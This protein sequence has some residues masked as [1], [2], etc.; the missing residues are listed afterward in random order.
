MKT[1]HGF[2]SNSSSSSFIVIA[3][4]EL[5]NPTNHYRDSGEPYKIFANGGE[6]EFG[7]QR[8]E[9]SD[10]ASKINF[11][12]IQ[13]TIMDSRGG[14]RKYQSMVEDA[15]V[16]YYGASCAYDAYQPSCTYG[17]GPYIDHASS[18]SECEN[19]EMFKSPE[20]L[21][22]FLFCSGSYI[23]NSNDNDYYDY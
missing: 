17:L 11:A 10:A 14:D 13:A 8:E 3:D 18:A 4:G 2:V 15:I 12:Y 5:E 22:Q 19:M 1:R 6:Y 7:W 16:E 23:Q 20:A 21:K 9:Y